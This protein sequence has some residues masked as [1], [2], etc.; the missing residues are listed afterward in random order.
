MRRHPSRPRRVHPAGHPHHHAA[1]PP[2]GSRSPTRGCSPSGGAVICGARLL[3][4]ACCRAHPAMLRP[5]WAHPAGQ[6]VPPRRAPTLRELLT[7]AGALTFRRRLIRA[8]PACLAGCAAAPTP[9]CRAPCEPPTPCV[10]PAL[11]RAR[12]AEARRRPPCGPSAPSEA[13]LTPREARSFC[14]APLALPVCVRA[15]PLQRSPSATPIPALRRLV[16]GRWRGQPSGWKRRGG[17]WMSK[18]IRACARIECGGVSGVISPSRS[19]KGNRA[20]VASRCRG[21]MTGCQM[22]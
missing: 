9:R 16:G 20:K 2:C 12:P 3:S 18:G 1:S 11:R 21:R 17:V 7:Y 6:P 15:R 13:A 10:A 4:R 22:L 14:R 8:A 19:N 5:L